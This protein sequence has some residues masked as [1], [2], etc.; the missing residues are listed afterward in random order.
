MLLTTSAGRCRRCTEDH[1]QPHGYP[2]S[3]CLQL[4]RHVDERLEGEGQ[5]VVAVGGGQVLCDLRHQR[6][7][8]RPAQAGWEAM[9][10]RWLK[11]GSSGCCSS[12]VCMQ[13]GSWTGAGQTGASNPW[14]LR[15]P[16]GSG[17]R[18]R[19]RRRHELNNARLAAAFPYRLLSHQV[20][21]GAR[22]RRCTRRQAPDLAA[23][24]SQPA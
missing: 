19:R 11:F 9:H 14:H 21:Q 15:Q 18:R 1:P 16:L 22:G 3:A 6:G 17:G 24:S 2:L 7:D 5:L 4:Q 8:G 12:C 13:Q 23:K 20:W 10:P